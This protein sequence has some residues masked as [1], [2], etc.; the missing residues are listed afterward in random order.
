[1]YVSEQSDG[2]FKFWLR[3]VSKIMSV[4]TAGNLER[5]EIFIVLKFKSPKIMS[6]VSRNIAAKSHEI[7]RVF[8]WWSLTVY[9]WLYF[10]SSDVILIR[11][12]HVSPSASYLPPSPHPTK[13]CITIVFHL[14]YSHPKRNWKQCLSKIWRVGRGGGTKFVPYGRCASGECDILYKLIK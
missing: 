11:H 2:F 6:K 1:M 5:L 13:F 12:L 4:N 10:F 9:T 14:N 3:S 7:L 8:V